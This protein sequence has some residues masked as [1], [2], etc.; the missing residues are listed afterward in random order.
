MFVYGVYCSVLMASWTF[1]NKSHVHRY[2]TDSMFAHT[3]K[4]FAA[5]KKI[6]IMANALILTAYCYVEKSN[7]FFNHLMHSI[8]PENKKC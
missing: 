6:A 5:I 8:S 2:R 3:V 1:K 4:Y 7:L